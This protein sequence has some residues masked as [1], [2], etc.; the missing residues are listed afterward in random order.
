MPEQAARVLFTERRAE[1]TQYLSGDAEIVIK[2]RS[3]LGVRDF[4][5]R[6]TGLR[7]DDVRYAIRDDL[8]RQQGHWRCG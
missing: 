6:M 3:G 5:Y 2:M 7:V 1:V 8:Q 4:E